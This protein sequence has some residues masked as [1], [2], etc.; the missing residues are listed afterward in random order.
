LGWETVA[1]NQ[2]WPLFHFLIIGSYST[3][4]LI[5]SVTLFASVLVT[6]WVSKRADKQG[7][8]G[9]LKIGSLA[10]AVVSVLHVFVES[11][12][13]AFMVNTGRSL[14][15]SIF[16]PPF[17][18]EYYLHADEESRSEYIYI[19]ESTVDIARLV[20]YLILYIL[21]LTYALPTV[22]IIGLLLGAFG[23]ALVALMPAAKCEICGEIINKEI[24]VA[25]RVNA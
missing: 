6:Y 9:F 24:K 21:S 15:Q 23:S 18:S 4:G 3:I 12:L 20:F 17:D 13:Q 22:L 11:T 10:T 25:R 16:K 7:R 19:M 5:T 14:T 1:S 2:I 8:V